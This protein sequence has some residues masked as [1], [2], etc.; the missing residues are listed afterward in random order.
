MKHAIRGIRAGGGAGSIINLSSIAAESGYSPYIGYVAAKGGVR[1]MTR[2][3]A[4]HCQERGYPIRVNSILPGALET[5]MGEDLLGLIEEYVGRTGE[6]PRLAAP[7]GPGTEKFYPDGQPDDARFG[8]GMGTP[9]TRRGP[10]ST[11]LRR[12]PLRQRNRLPHRQ[13]RFDPADL[14][15]LSLS[16]PLFRIGACSTLGSTVRWEGCW[17]WSGRWWPGSTS[18]SSMPS[19]LLGWWRSAPRPSVSLLRSASLRRPP[20]RTTRCGGARSTRCGVDA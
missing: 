9:T 17:D 20:W 14:I 10:S 6:M 4:I 1:A 12:V 15:G 11:G 16:H 19:R 13:R 2:A 7:K 18:G 3:A 5:P 8:P